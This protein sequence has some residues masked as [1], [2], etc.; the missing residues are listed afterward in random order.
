MSG[1]GTHIVNI[2]IARIVASLTSYVFQ[3]SHTK[4]KTKI[5]IIKSQF[6][7]SRTTNVSPPL[8]PK[9]DRCEPKQIAAYATLFH[10]KLLCDIVGQL[11]LQDVA[12]TTGICKFWRDAICSRSDHPKR[13]FPSTANRTSQYLPQSFLHP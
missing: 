4:F 13:S 11:P 8:Q 10:P 5:M 9:P 2:I 7:E 12:A 1:S 3:P 6:V